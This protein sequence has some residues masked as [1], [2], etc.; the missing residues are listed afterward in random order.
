MVIFLL[1]M[2]LWKV[3][4]DL[5]RDKS[6]RNL[7]SHGSF[8]LEWLSLFLLTFGRLCSSSDWVKWVYLISGSEKASALWWPRANKAS[9]QVRECWW[10]GAF[11][12][13]PISVN[14]RALKGSLHKSC[15]HGLLLVFVFFLSPHQLL[16]KAV[17]WKY[18]CEAGKAQYRALAFC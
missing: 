6:D 11:L 12:C 9:N 10:T 13:P 14:S 18:T 2:V 7:K 15:I 4:D 3:I 5:L 16:W 8:S 1:Q 17:L